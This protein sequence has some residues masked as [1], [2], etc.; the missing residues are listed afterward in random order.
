MTH[1]H[2]HYRVSHVSVLRVEAAGLGHRAGEEDVEGAE[3]EG[4]ELRVEWPWYCSRQ[5][6]I[7]EATPI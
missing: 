4:L 5:C 3:D 7:M 2:T 6:P 1:K